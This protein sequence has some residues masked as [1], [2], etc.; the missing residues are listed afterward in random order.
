V[1][2]TNG[3]RALNHCKRFNN[4]FCAVVLT[5]AFHR[6]KM[7]TAVEQIIFHEDCFQAATLGNGKGKKRLQ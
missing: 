3:K 6:K 5:R 4:A 2:A 7:K 1:S